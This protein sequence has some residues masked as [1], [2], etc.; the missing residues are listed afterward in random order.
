MGNG[1]QS[2]LLG[3]R[4]RRLVSWLRLMALSQLWVGPGASGRFGQVY[5]FIRS[6]AGRKRG[7]E[8]GKWETR[9][10]ED[11]SRLEGNVCIL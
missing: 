4:E 7:R 8:G 9:R 2:G 10:K 1:E 5:D 11:G 6:M 3:T